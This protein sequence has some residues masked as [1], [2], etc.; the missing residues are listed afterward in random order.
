MIPRALKRILIVVIVFAV[1]CVAPLQ[2]PVFA[3]TKASKA[4]KARITG[5]ATYR[6]RIALSPDAVFEATLEEA[7]RTD[8]HAEIIK[9]VRRRSPGQV[10]I[11]FEIA[12]DPRRIDA[13]RTYVLRASIY[14][15][16]RLRF[17]SDHAS[18]VL[19]HGNGRKV[20][21]LMRRTSGE[22][23]RTTGGHTVAPHSHRR[24]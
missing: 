4:S 17:T 5:F 20:S 13:R 22:G 7:S 12:Y 11:A 6:E 1:S 9:K 23:R 16:G 8:G 3:A 21:V 15:D 14:E 10:P 18:P 2:G 19:T 24:P